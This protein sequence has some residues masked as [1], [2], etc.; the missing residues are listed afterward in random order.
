[1]GHQR[2]DLK[3]YN[4]HTMMTWNIRSMLNKLKMVER[5]ELLAS[6]ESL[7]IVESWMILELDN[8]L[9]KISGYNIFRQDWTIESGTSK[10][11]GVKWYF[12]DCH[13]LINVQCTGTDLIARLGRW[14]IQLSSEHTTKLPCHDV[15]HPGS[16]FR[17]VASVLFSLL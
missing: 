5:I 10:G 1:M 12:R 4:G 17:R 3:Q 9:I 7:G 8:D 2:E 15:N 13:S 14:R 16:R 11:D 6:S